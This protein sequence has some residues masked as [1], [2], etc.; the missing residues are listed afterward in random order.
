MRATV[1]GSAGRLGS[2]AYFWFRLSPTTE[3]LPLAPETL[4]LVHT[5]FAGTVGVVAAEDE[6]VRGVTLCGGGGSWACARPGHASIPRT[7]SG[8]RSRPNIS[9]QTGRDGSSTLNPV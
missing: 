7:K 1:A 2:I 8:E 9:L 6:V 5:F 4:S 3:T